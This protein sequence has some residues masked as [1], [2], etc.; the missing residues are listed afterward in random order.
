MKNL[1]LCTLVALATCSLLAGITQ[2]GQ[3]PVHIATAPTATSLRDAL[4]DIT[5]AS[6]GGDV[7]CRKLLERCDRGDVWACAAWERN[8]VPAD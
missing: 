2:A 1:A 8:C 7:Y 4:R 5:D 3:L 6:I